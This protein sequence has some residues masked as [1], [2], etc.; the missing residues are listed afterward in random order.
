LSIN[1]DQIMFVTCGYIYMLLI[2]KTL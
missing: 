2:N 1:N